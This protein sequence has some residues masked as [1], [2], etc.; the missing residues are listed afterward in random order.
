MKHSALLDQMASIAKLHEQIRS[1]AS[2]RPHR[3]RAKPAARQRRDRGRREEDV[4]DLTTGDSAARS[5][6]AAS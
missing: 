4:T 1:H 3:P 5:Q 6:F 2:R